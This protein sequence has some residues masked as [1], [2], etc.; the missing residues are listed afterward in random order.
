MAAPDTALFRLAAWAGGQAIHQTKDARAHYD[1]SGPMWQSEYWTVLSLGPFSSNG[2]V[3]NTF[4]KQL[5]AE[6]AIRPDG[7][8]DPNALGADEFDRKDVFFY[9]V[10]ALSLARCG[11]VCLA[12]GRQSLYSAR[13]SPGS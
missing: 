2:P 13:N 1:T 6:H 9:Q 4:W 5:C 12:G 3:G 10:S 11:F 8:V 7:T